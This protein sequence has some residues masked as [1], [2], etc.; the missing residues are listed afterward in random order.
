MKAPPFR[1]HAP[2]T[3]EEALALATTLP[4]PRLLAGG[5]SLMPMLN[6]RLLAPEHVIDLNRVAGLSGISEA[7]GQIV[8]GAMTRQRDIEFS[9]LVKQRLPLLA[10]AMQ[11]VGHRQTRNRGTIGG[12]LCHLDPSAEQPTVA[13]AMD[14]IL[15][16]AG[17]AGRRELPMRAFAAD[18]M[19]PA[20]EDGEILT[21]VRIT[22]WSATHGWAFLEFARRHG[23]FA[24]V[25]VAVLLERDS[26]GHATRVSITLG[27]VAATAT[28]VPEAEAALLGSTISADDIAAAAACC[29]QVAA[30][31]DPQVPA[32]YRQRL[33]RTLCERA[34]PIAAA[35]ALAH[36]AGAGRHT[37]EQ[38]R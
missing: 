21:E 4:S 36:P 19:T 1:Y 29:G 35:R 26:D 25:A 32:W 6:F 38:T 23:D 15:A 33:A 22:P 30:L 31:G 18:L 28:R 3:L 14:A 12:S 11:W 2:R 16:I 13:M 10:E 5:Q 37:K 8:F 27:G 34:I 9:P 7:G 17:P 24:I 20:L